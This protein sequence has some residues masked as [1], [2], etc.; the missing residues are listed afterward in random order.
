MCGRV[1]V[2]LRPPLPRPP[3]PRQVYGVQPGG[4]CTL[5]ARSDPHGEFKGRNVLMQVRWCCTI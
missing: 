4:N 5:D 2:S 1:V 3:L